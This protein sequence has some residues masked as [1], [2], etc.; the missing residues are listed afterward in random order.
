FPHNKGGAYRKWWGNQDFVVDWNGDGR[1]IRGFVDSFGRQR[2]RPQNADYYLLE[3]VSWSNI[4][5][6]SPAFRLFPP[7]FIFGHKG[8]AIFLD[9]FS[10]LKLMGF[11]NSV[12]AERFLE[13][14]APTLSF[15]VGH[16]AQLPFVSVP[17]SS[18][19][20]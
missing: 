4:S 1:S 7:G 18:A 2:S 16:I 19:A 10:L 13:I 15:E 11:L 9:R 6:G 14:L 12:A 8:P 3:C 17:S 20:S 5:T